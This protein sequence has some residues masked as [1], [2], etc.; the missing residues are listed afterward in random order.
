MYPY[1]RPLK[2]NYS[3][4]HRLIFQRGLVN[5]AW[6]L[7]VANSPSITDR[8]SKFIGHACRVAS[9]SEVDEA[10]QFI[11]ASKIAQK[12][13]HPAINAWRIEVDGK[14]IEGSSDDGE[15]NAGQLLLSLLRTRNHTSHLVA[16]TRI[17]GGKQLGGDR[18]RHIR[19][20]AAESLER[21]KDMGL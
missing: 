12:A 16:V 5:D 17:Y 14:I 8:R 3:I 19:T 20:V 9:S 13:T 4:I 7:R 2:G 10:L 21:L 11:R 18:F 1:L 6:G 15:A